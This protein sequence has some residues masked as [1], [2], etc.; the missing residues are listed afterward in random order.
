MIDGINDTPDDARGLA[1]SAARPALAH[2]NL[3]P[4]N[5]VAHTPWQPSTRRAHRGIRGVLRARRA[6]HDRAPQPRR[7][8]RRRVRPARG[9]A[10]GRARPR[11][12]SRAAGSCWSTESAAALRAAGAPRMTVRRGDSVAASILTADFGNLYRVVRKLERAGVDRLHLDVMDGHFV[13]NI[14]FG[15]DVVAAFRRLTALPLDV[16][17]MIYRAVALRDRFL[18]RRRRTPSRSTSRSTEPEST[19]AGRRC[20]RI[21][22]AGRRRPGDQPGTPVDGRDAVRRPARRSS[23]S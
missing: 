6:R 21:R 4:M 16:H 3:I 18:R 9:R 15:P 23:W 8:D 10:G 7:R 5:P 2:V 11:R 13:P 17:L 14:T 19:Q 22:D 1:A 20:E 12:P